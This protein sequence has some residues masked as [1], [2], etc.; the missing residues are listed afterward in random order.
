MD[1]YAA[2]LKELQE[3]MMSADAHADPNF[4][5]KMRRMAELTEIKS[6]YDQIAQ[7]E[8]G[9]A[10]AK[11]LADDPELGALAKDDIA[12]LTAK[13]ADLNAKLE[14]LT[15]PR[16]PDDDK[17]AILEIRA[18]AGGDEASLCRRALSYV[19]EIC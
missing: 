12:N 10:E 6:T 7:A 4:G 1:K 13:I 15:I 9:L 14:E 19:F 2:E 11:E 18:G 3:F 16:D 5:A 8:Q 17:P